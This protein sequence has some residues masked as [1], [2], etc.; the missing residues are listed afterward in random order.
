MQYNLASQ[1]HEQSSVCLPTRIPNFTSH[2]PYHYPH[3]SRLNHLGGDDPVVKLPSN[4]VLALT[5]SLPQPAKRKRREDKKRTYSTSSQSSPA[6]ASYLQNS[7]FSHSQL[8]R[9]CFA[10]GS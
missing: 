3:S 5:H 10:S 1:G 4:Q 2:P 8:R 7:A 6:P 9:R